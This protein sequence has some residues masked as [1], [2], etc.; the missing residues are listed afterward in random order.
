MD[1]QQVIWLL[2]RHDLQLDAATVA[3]HEQQ[4]LI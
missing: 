4:P 2:N 1:H 3:A